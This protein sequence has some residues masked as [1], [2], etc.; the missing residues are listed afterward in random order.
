MRVCVHETHTSMGVR[1]PTSTVAGTLLS[2]STCVSPAGNVSFALHS[3]R[4]LVTGAPPAQQEEKKQPPP[5]FPHWSPDLLQEEKK[6]IETEEQ[7]PSANTPDSHGYRTSTVMENTLATVSQKGDGS[8]RSCRTGSD[9]NKH[10]E[11]SH[12]SCRTKRKHTQN[13]GREMQA[14]RW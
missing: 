2:T 12:H 4:Q 11:A 9:S 10:M 14:H 3:M 1:F 7:A 13:K 6:G 5:P 8:G